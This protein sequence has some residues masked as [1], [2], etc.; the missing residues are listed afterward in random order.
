ML[1]RAVRASNIAEDVCSIRRVTGGTGGE[2]WRKQGVL[3]EVSQ[4]VL[5]TTKSSVIVTNS[6]VAFLGSTPGRLRV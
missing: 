2:S 6:H 3:P 4:T 5:K 1:E